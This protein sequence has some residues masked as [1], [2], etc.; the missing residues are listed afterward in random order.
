MQTRLTVAFTLLAVAAVIAS[1]LVTLQLGVRRAE[2]EANRRLTTA[3]SFS[4]ALLT[5]ERDRNRID[6]LE[7]ASR[8]TVQQTVAAVH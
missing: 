1:A 3:A 4:M 6:A 7:V 5:A 2:A 8:L